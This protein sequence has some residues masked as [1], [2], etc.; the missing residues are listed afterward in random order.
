MLDSKAP[1]SAPK[2][3]VKAGTCPIDKHIG[4]RAAERRQALGL[5][6]G[7][8]AQALEVDCALLDRLEGGHQRF[9]ARQLWTLSRRLQVPMAW[10]FKVPGETS[11]LKTPSPKADPGKAGPGEPVKA[12]LIFVPNPDLDPAGDGEPVP[13]H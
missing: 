5:A 7:E 11:P 10:F 1:K 6:L 12:S 2:T 8:V 13:L 4:G 3:G 9:A